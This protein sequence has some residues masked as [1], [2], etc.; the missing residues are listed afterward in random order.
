[1][2]ILAKPL[3]IVQVKGCLLTS[4]DT[5]ARKPFVLHCQ[6]KGTVSPVGA[7]V[8]DT[9]YCYERIE[10]E[11]EAAYH[12][13]LV[14]TTVKSKEQA[15]R[16]TFSLSFPFFPPFSTTVGTSYDVLAC[17]STPHV[18][19]TPNAAAHTATCH[20]V[21]LLGLGLHLPL[22]PATP[23]PTPFMQILSSCS[24]GENITICK[25]HYYSLGTNISPWRRWGYLNFSPSHRRVSQDRWY[26]D[27][28]T[29]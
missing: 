25:N 14:V 6:S 26:D 12:S 5:T 28:C 16:L 7:C 20:F 13:H 29:L 8:Q 11:T 1:M 27:R 23:I 17:E 18:C 2:P 24:L 9:R 15:V 10:A 21:G 4:I 3:S 22:F 19:P